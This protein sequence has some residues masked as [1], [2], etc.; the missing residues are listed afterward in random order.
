M[1][2]NPPPRAKPEDL[3]GYLEALSRP[4]FRAGISWRVIDAKWDG[5]RD[6]FLGFDPGAVA[7]FGPPEIQRL[8]ADARVVRSK[9]KI[10]ATIDNAQALLELDAEFGGFDRY[11]RSHAGFAETVADLKRQFRF[12]GDSGAYHF[13]YVVDEPVRRATSGSPARAPLAVDAAR[14]PGRQGSRRTPRAPRLPAVGAAPGVE[15]GHRGAHRSHADDQ[16]AGRSGLRRSRRRGQLRRVEPDHQI[17]AQAR[18]SAD[19]QRFTF[20]WDLRGFGRVV[21]E[22]QEFEPNSRVRIVPHIKTLEG[23]HRFRLAAEGGATRLDHELKVNPKGV[24]RLFTPMM[25]IIGRK[26]LA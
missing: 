21:Q 7:D 2:G 15:S 14:P 8:L 22:F 18:R 26:N 5:I 6:A 3:A 16:Q 25:G 17:L 12:I 11:L 20:E 4:V 10:E 19:W 23:G 1:D 13:L 24:F 9:A